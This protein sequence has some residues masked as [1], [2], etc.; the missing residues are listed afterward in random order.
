MERKSREY[1]EL[2]DRRLALRQNCRVDFLVVEHP[3][4]GIVRTTVLDISR[5]GF[6]LLMPVSVPC[7]DGII[8]HPPEGSGLLKI[9]AAIVRQRMVTRDHRT[10]V[11]CGVEVADTAEW[12]KHAWFLALRTGTHSESPDGQMMLVSAEA[13]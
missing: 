4:A 13:A 5:Q 9:R 2:A 8:I 12:R 10:M 1:P 7:G 11:D 6:R 3:T